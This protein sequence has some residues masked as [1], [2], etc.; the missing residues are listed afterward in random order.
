MIYLTSIIY[1]KS[2]SLAENPIAKAQ[3]NSRKSPPGKY[4][5]NTFIMS[6]KNEYNYL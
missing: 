6:R 3:L 1:I 4:F 2:N 5:C